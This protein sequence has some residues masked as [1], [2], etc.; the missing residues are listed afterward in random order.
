MLDHSDHFTYTGHDSNGFNQEGMM[1]EC[2]DWPLPQSC[3]YQV[4]AQPPMNPSPQAED[5]ASSIFPN[6]TGQPQTPTYQELTQQCIPPVSL[7][8]H[9]HESMLFMAQQAEMQFMG[10]M[11]ILDSNI[12]IEKPYLQIV[13]IPSQQQMHEMQKKLPYSHQGVESSG[14]LQIYCDAKR[15]SESA[16]SVSVASK[17]KRTAISLQDKGKVLNYVDQNPDA[18]I[19]EIA[20]RFQMCRTTIYGIMNSRSRILERLNG[21]T[22]LPQAS[23]VHDSYRVSESRFLILEELLAIWLKDLKQQWIQVSDNKIMTQARELYR[24]LSDRPQVPMDPCRFTSGWLKGFQKRKNINPRGTRKKIGSESLSVEGENHFASLRVRRYK[25]CDIYSCETTSMHLNFVAPNFLQEKSQD[26]ATVR[27]GEP[28]ALKAIGYHEMVD[29]A[30][31]EDLKKGTLIRWLMEFDR[32]LVHPILLFVDEAIWRLLSF[33]GEDSGSYLRLIDVIKVPGRHAGSSPMG[34]GIAKEFKSS[35]Y[36]HLISALN[37]RAESLG[38]VEN[39]SKKLDTLEEHLGLILTAWDKIHS[40]DIKRLFQKFLEP[41]G[42]AADDIAS[43]SQSIQS[44][45][46]STMLP[47]HIKDSFP[48]MSNAVIQY[49]ANLDKDTGPSSFMRSKIQQISRHPDFFRYFK[50]GGVD[51]VR[52]AKLYPESR[53]DLDFL[54][55][56]RVLSLYRD[57][58][59]A[60]RSVKDPK[61]RQDLQ[62]WARS[63]FERYRH[64]TNPDKIK[65]LISQGKHQFHALQTNLSLSSGQDSKSGK[66]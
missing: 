3:K 8:S 30:E 34:A 58:Q 12:Q 56:A 11:Q 7:Q 66:K 35:Y 55:R 1:P 62:T 28:L 23:L 63:D 49:F 29:D 40:R 19:I 39:N 25:K 4:Q 42:P 9:C 5:A 22:N 18:T 32:T 48:E 47:G 6:P 54:T 38:G 60:I 57:I 59:R 46:Y 26:K 43:R 31:A 65:S 21:V 61:D 37:H 17:R 15:S 45:Y 51:I 24:M 41:I 16:D 44:F 10:N 33:D 27:Q 13:Q 36:W 2:Y 20:D 53:F 50:H 52:V 64:E 14:S